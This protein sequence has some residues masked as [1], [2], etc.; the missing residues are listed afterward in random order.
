[1]I[2]ALAIYIALTRISDY[3]HHPGDVITGTIVGNIFALLILI[4]MVDVFR[5]PRS[6]RDLKYTLIDGIIEVRN[7]N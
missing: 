5:R 2:Y 7:L 4:F 1:M 6:F 3:R